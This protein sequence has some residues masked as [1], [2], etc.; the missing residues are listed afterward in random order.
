MTNSTTV[1]NSDRGGLIHY[2]LL[3]ELGHGTFGIASLVL[4]LPT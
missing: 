3:H 4:H 2:K 1:N